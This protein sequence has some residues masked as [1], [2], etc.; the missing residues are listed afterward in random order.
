MTEI[1]NAKAAITRPAG[2]R[3]A[4]VLGSL[5]L[6]VACGDP[7]APATPPFTGTGG[8]GGTGGTG[9]MAG[10]GGMVGTGGVAGTGGMVGTGGMPGT[11]GMVGTG[12]IGGTGGTGGSVGACVTTALCHTCPS[13]ALSSTLQCD[14]GGGCTFPGYVCVPSGC[15]THGGAPIGQCQPWRGGSCADDDDCPDT[16]DHA[17]RTVGAGVTRCV[18]VAGDCDPMTESYDCL[19]GFSCEDGTCVDRRVPCDDYNDCPKSYVCSETKTGDFCVRVYRTCHVDTDC[20][21]FGPYC[22]DVDG[23][24]I[25]ECAGELNGSKSPCTNSDCISRSAPVCEAGSSG[26]TA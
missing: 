11:G 24:G 6:A 22:A 10:A 1:T 18:R 9:G 19:P 2:A 12:G 20:A 8:S 26:A 14:I 7:S 4:F 23:D 25:K 3:W 13:E 5:A 17:C 15:E 21:G 16:G